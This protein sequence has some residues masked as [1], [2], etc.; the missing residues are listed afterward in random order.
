MAITVIGGLLFS[1][2]I[3]LVFIPVIYA[4]VD[5]VRSKNERRREERKRARGVAVVREE[6]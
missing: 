6:A 4:Y 1:T 5:D 3:T 2:V